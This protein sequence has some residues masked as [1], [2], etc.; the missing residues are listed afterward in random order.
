MWKFVGRDGPE[1]NIP[2]C[3]FVAVLKCWDLLKHVL[4]M[5]EFSIL[6]TSWNDFDFFKAQ[7]APL[8]WLAQYEAWTGGGTWYLVQYLGGWA[9]LI[10]SLFILLLLC[11]KIGQV[12]I[13]LLFL[14]SYSCLCFICANMPRR[15][16]SLKFLFIILC[17]QMLSDYKNG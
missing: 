3:L 1:L 16:Y 8:L 15:T 13:L 2:C 10:L 9:V 4:K 17:N 14:E 6:V 7:A 5:S 11:N 12:S